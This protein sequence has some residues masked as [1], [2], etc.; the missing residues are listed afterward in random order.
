MTSQ[1]VRDCSFEYYWQNLALKSLLA[2]S[3][4]VFLKLN[5][6]FFIFHPCLHMSLYSVIIRLGPNISDQY[7]YLSSMLTH[8]SLYSWVQTQL[9]NY[10]D[11]LWEDGVQDYTNHASNIM[12]GSKILKFYIEVILS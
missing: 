4:M 8:V 5:Y 2:Y 1:I 7:C 11:E 3:S 12:V 6:L 10:P 9:Q